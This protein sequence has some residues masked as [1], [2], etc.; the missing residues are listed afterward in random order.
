MYIEE[1]ESKTKWGIA[2]IGNISIVE[3]SADYFGTYRHFYFWCD[4]DYDTPSFTPILSSPHVDVLEKDD[5]HRAAK[6][7]EVLLLIFNGIQATFENGTRKS[8]GGITEFEHNRVRDHFNLKPKPKNPEEKSPNNNFEEDDFDVF[9]E[10]L[11]NPF[12][13]HVVK[14]IRNREPIIK[15]QEGFMMEMAIDDDISRNILIWRSLCED[16]KI[17][18]ITNAYKIYDAVNYFLNKDEKYEENKKNPQ[19]QELIKQHKI[20]Q[21][22]KHFMNTFKFAGLLSRHGYSNHVAPAKADPKA[23][24]KKL[25]S[26]LNNLVLSWFKYWHDTKEVHQ[27]EKTDALKNVMETTKKIH[28]EADEILLKLN[29]SFNIHK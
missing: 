23:N 24:L 13:P 29:N 3:K 4:D 11:N 28:Q 6:R 7:L 1:P 19:M 9:M 18:F 15:T 8:Q 22:N 14:Y 26:D 12:D 10:E 5:A 25:R 20:M 27:K 2:L 16:D 21:S 17:H